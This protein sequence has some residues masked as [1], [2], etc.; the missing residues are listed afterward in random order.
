MGM[1]IRTAGLEIMIILT[2]DGWMFLV[3]AMVFELGF[4]IQIKLKIYTKIK[5]LM[6]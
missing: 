1:K 5:V 6:L 3:I 4:Q 2:I